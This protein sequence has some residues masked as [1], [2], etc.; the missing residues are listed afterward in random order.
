MTNREQTAVWNEVVGD[1]WVRHADRFDATL[2]PLGAAAISA[3]DLRR[4][5]R[6][7]DIGCGAGATSLALAAAV[8]PG[9]VV[10]IDLS[11]P[12]LAE[13]QRRADAAGI[14]NVTFV[15]GDAQVDKP[16]GAPFDVAYSR[17]GVMFFDDPAAAFANIAHWLVPG[18]RLGFICFKP[19]AAN[20]FITGPVMATA[21]VLGLAPPD[22]SE[23]SPFSLADPDRTRALLAEA[24]FTDITFDDGPTEAVL[25]RDEDTSTLALRLIEQH[26]VAGVAL[27]A[28]TDSVRAQAIA[29]TAAVLDDH[30][31]D[32]EVRMGTGTWLVFAHRAQ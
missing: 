5:E 3:L 18:G 8:M 14:D 28:A 26:P 13:A 12:M 22:P 15:R 27:A 4:G 9:P 31:V 2:E 25:T 1:A 21:S 16:V 30:R 20:P 11:A 6:V 19:P 24:G 29:A 32:D 17:F 23:P 10:G 7:V